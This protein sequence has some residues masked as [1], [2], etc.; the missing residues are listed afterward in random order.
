MK[1]R[2][3]KA[4]NKDKIAPPS[5]SNSKERCNKKLIDGLDKEVLQHISVN[6]LF[7]QGEVFSAVST[8]DNPLSN[9]SAGHL[10][11]KTPSPP[12]KRAEVRTSLNMAFKVFVVLLLLVFFMF[13]GMPMLFL[14]SLYKG[15]RH[16]K[17]D[18]GACAQLR[19]A[20]VG[21]NSFAKEL[22]WVQLP[23]ASIRKERIRGLYG[24]NEDYRSL[25]EAVSLLEKCCGNSVTF[26]KAPLT[27]VESL[28]SFLEIP[29]KQEVRSEQ[30][31]VYWVELEHI[32]PQP[33]ANALKELL[34]SN[35]LRFQ[36]VIPP[37][38]KALLIISS[39]MSKE[40]LKQILPHRVVHL[41]HFV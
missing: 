2:H 30:C 20:A 40:E 15:D 38:S 24:K 10:E 27:S 29:I 21:G 37:L 14:S 8:H 1:R 22:S 25:R 36:E 3:S 28:K 31:F 5:F 4:S 18:I 17:G 9:G 26:S 32:A 35:V 7:S 6:A 13:G 41:L 19:D 34:E 39:S 16:V 33:T 12:D 11:V 23:D